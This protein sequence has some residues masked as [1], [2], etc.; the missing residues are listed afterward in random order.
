[1]DIFSRKK[2]SEIM[3][4]VKNKDSKIE[5]LFRKEIWKAGFRYRKNSSNYFGKPDLV[6]NVEDGLPYEDESIDNII[7]KDF[8]EHIHPDKVI[9]V[10]EEIWRVLKTGCL[11]EHMTPSTEG[12]GAW[13]DPTHR[14]F[15]NKNSWMYYTM[16]DARELIGTKANFKIIA[17]QDQ[18]TNYDLRIIHTHGI[19]E[20]IGAEHG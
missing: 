7:A 18:M 19:L 8:L 14:S 16:P 4:K 3:S 15:W 5:I 13:Q 12:R 9:F 6:L 2:R 17:M 10:I 11:F 1:M 20:K